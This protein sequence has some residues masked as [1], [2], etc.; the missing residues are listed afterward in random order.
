VSG[1]RRGHEPLAPLRHPNFAFYMGARLFSGVAMTLLQAVMAWQVN[2]LSGSTGDA[3]LHLGLLGLVRF[4][5]A[6]G[7][8]LVGGAVADTYNRR[9]IVIAAQVLPVL[10]SLTLA[11]ATLGGWASIGLVYGL[12]LVVAVASSFENPAGA[13]LLPAIVPADEFSTAVTLSNSARQLGFVTGPAIT[14]VLIALGGVHT[15]YFSHAAILCGS[16]ALM[17]LVRYDQAAGSR[18][19]VSLQ[20]IVEGVR[21]V[22]QRQVLLGAMTLDMFAVIFGGATALLPIYAT[23]ILHVGARGYGVLQAS[24]EFGAFLMA[25]ILVTRPPVVNAGRSLLI[26]VAIFGAGTMVFGASRW[27]PLSLLAYTAI[28]MAD[29][30]SVVL[31]QTT[32]QL[33]TPDEL[34]GRVSSVSQLFI[35]ASNQ[36]GALESGLVAAITSATFAVVS[37]GAGCLAV[38]GL[39]T[40]KLPELRRYRIMQPAAEVA[41]VE[42]QALPAQ[43]SD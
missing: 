2:S 15:A 3:A 27:F 16:L 12:V 31:R 9:N 37:G 24:F 33:S 39:V 14:G 35:G 8:S 22:R 29:Q 40:A 19:A 43:A 28:G 38:V 10:C 23:D 5:P 32:I 13:A 41:E 18:R 20:A 11:F 21:F 7:L 36:L 4:F 25:V 26:T 17:A 30:L 34:R 1:G 42:R 6:L